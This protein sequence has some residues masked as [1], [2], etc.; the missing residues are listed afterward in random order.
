MKKNIEYGLFVTVTDFL[1][2]QCKVCKP[3]E[4]V[5]NENFVVLIPLKFE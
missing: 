3:T 4:V 5:A 1:Q 2:V